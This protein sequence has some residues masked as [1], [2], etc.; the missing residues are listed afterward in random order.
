MEPI[1]IHPSNYIPLAKGNDTPLT[2]KGPSLRET[3]QSF[4]AFFILEVLREMENTLEEGSI[5]GGG[6][7]GK[8]F[9]DI[10]R[11]ELAQ[12]IS[13]QS[14]LGIADAMVEQLTSRGETP[15]KSEENKP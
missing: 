3:A 4:E 11:W 15:P 14:H 1:S 2:G 5:F 8:T 9:G 13:Q 6:I 12:R 10:A 7:E